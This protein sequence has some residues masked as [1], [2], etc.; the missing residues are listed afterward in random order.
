MNELLNEL[1]CVGQL[2]FILGS[3]WNAGVALATFQRFTS[4]ETVE[5]RD[6]HFSHSRCAV[7]PVAA[8]LQGLLSRLHPA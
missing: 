3:G 4:V 2:R 7:Q 8:G 6:P 1:Y 5:K